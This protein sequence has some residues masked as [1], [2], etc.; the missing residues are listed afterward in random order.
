MISFLDFPLRGCSVPRKKTDLVTKLHT[1][2]HRRLNTTT[3]M[4]NTYTYTTASYF[5]CVMFTA[6]L[7]QLLTLSSVSAFT[8][9]FIQLFLNSF[10]YFTFLK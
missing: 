8:L 10:F 3:M 7:R 1:T 2:R 9:F 5:Q 6:L 4:C